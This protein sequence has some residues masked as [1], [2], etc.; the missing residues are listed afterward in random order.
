MPEEFAILAKHRILI[1]NGR[2]LDEIICQSCEEGHF[3]PVQYDE[4]RPYYVCP[5]EDAERSY[6]SAEQL[7]MWQLD[8]E[9]LI[10]SWLAN[11]T[12]GAV[13]ITANVSGRLWSAG[14]HNIN[15]KDYFLY[16]LSDVNSLN[17]EK[18]FSIAGHL[19][20][21][22]VFYAGSPSVSLPTNI[23][24]VPFS[25]VIVVAAKGVKVERRKLLR[26][27][28]RDVFV[29]GPDAIELDK[30]ICLVPSRNKLLLHSRKGGGY[31]KEVN[32]PPQLKEIVSY[33]YNRRGRDERWATLDALQE[34]FARDASETKIGKTS[35]SNRIKRIRDLCEKQGVKHIL[36]K[37]GQ[38]GWELNPKLDCCKDYSPRHSPGWR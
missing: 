33:L 37:R 23:L 27:F 14:E 29:A 20:N 22:A 25:E 16:F 30:N 35:V 3:V 5:Y 10:K 26:F 31:E 1:K 19:D 21:S 15:G 9:A 6:I 34:R 11:I 4:G 13:D 18:V 32:I 7:E 24:L 36:I 8:F 38:S 17:D 28:P 2:P 12:E